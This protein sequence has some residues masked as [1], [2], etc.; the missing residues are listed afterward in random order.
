[1]VF[2][3]KKTI[4]SGYDSRGRTRVPAAPHY[5]LHCRPDRWRRP[6]S[7]G[8]RPWPRPP[9]PFIGDERRKMAGRVPVGGGAARARSPVRVQLSIRPPSSRPCVAV[10]RWQKRKRRKRIRC[11]HI[12]LNV[13]TELC[14]RRGIKGG[15]RRRRSHDIMSEEQRLHSYIFK[16]K[17]TKQKYFCF[18]F[19]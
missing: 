10:V 15:T 13:T 17:K 5:T 3:E 14:L 11:T 7:S 2:W 4:C 9:T 6:P 19:E 16:L 1:M 12:L 18:R 8:R